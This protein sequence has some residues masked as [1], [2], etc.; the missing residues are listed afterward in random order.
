MSAAILPLAPIGEAPYRFTLADLIVDIAGIAS[1]V[2][3]A[4]A[5]ARSRRGE[6]LATALPHFRHEL[7]EAHEALGRMLDR[8]SW[9]EGVNP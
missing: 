4:E 8:I 9:A 1:D 6:D 2:C 3:C 7:H 5:A